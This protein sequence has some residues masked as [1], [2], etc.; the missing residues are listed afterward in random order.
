MKP[1]SRV[2]TASHSWRAGWKRVGDSIA[3]AR[4]MCWLSAAPFGTGKE[5]KGA[6]SSLSSLA[7]NPCEL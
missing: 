2:S 6:Y 7:S 5:G 1:P 3:E 4:G